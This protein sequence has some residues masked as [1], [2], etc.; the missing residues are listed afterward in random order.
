MLRLSKGSCRAPCKRMGTDGGGSK[1][2]SK[3]GGKEYGGG[4]E[5]REV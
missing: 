3:G 4:R 5:L 1:E 2:E